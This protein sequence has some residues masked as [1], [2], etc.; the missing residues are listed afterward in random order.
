MD[1]FTCGVTW[2]QVLE[3]G[4]VSRF[5]ITSIAANSVQVPRG[6]NLGGQNGILKLLCSASTQF[7]LTEPM[8][9]HGREGTPITGRSKMILC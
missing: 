4:T 6:V 1:D 5:L 2:L 9:I 8:Q 7:G 3:M